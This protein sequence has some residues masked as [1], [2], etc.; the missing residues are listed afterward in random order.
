MPIVTDWISAGRRDCCGRPANRTLIEPRNGYVAN[1]H[2]QA[3]TRSGSSRTLILPDHV[4]RLLDE[5]RQRSIT[6]QAGDPVFSSRNGTWLYPQNLR[7]RLRAA[8]PPSL[9]GTTPHTLRRTVASRIAHEVGLDAARDQLGH[10]AAGVTWQSY[11]AQ[12]QTAPDVRSVL[13][14]LFDGLE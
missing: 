6:S 4:A 8:I 7:T 14:D 3:A 9:A 13:D 12:R 11:V 2:R 1:L 5:R 10:S